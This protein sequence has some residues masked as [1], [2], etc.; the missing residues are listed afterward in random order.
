MFSISGWSIYIENMLSC[1]ICYAGIPSSWNGMKNVPA[2]Y[3]RKNKF[4]K[5]SL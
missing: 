1:L 5:K 3:K 2:S 4:M